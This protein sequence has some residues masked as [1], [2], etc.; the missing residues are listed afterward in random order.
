MIWKVINQILIKLKGKDLKLNLIT[1]IG[2]HCSA[3]QECMV[4]RELLSKV[5][6]RKDNDGY[7]HMDIYTQHID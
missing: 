1:P 6:Y 4:I 2:S 7:I 3:A 5:H